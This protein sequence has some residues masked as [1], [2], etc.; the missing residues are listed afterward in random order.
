MKVIVTKVAEKKI[1]K[2]IPLITKEDLTREEVL[3]Q[4]VSFVSLSGETLGIGYLSKQ[5]KGIGWF[6]SSKETSIQE[7]WLCKLFMQ[8]K[9]KRERLL[10]DE[11]TNAFRLFNG[12]GDGFGGFVIDQY[13]SY[14]V[15]HWYNEFVYSIRERIIRAFREVFPEI[16]GA[17]EKNRFDNPLCENAHLFGN[18]GQF[19]MVVKENGVN[20]AVYLDEG[21]MT[22]IFL[23]QREVRG[24]LVDGLLAGK[25]VLN[26]FSYTGAFSVAASV[27]GATQT[28]SVDLAKRS[29]E[30]TR[31][32]FEV[33]GLPVEQQKIYV[34]DVFRYFDYAK[35]HQLTYD[36]IILDPPSFARNG[37]KSFSVAKNYGELIE[38]S[39]E[40]L[41]KNGIIIASANAANITREKFQQNI[42]TALKKK[43]VQYQFF[44]KKSLP[45]DFPAVKGFSESDYLKV[46]FIKIKF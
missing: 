17:Y 10:Q 31:E 41:S 43:N 5:N 30:K 2:G 14:A 38:Q 19:P 29:L 20:Y 9:A 34:M 22:G 21:W 12:E 8:A 4:E 27:G 11:W 44:D 15:F 1:K 6:L 36:T 18:V 3:N 42:E 16:E 40:I 23:D 39:V 24:R 37:K 46:F 35:K 32:Q 13:D 7:V 45:E 28:T 25:N 33:N 26:M